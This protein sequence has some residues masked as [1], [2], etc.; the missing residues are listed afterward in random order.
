MIGPTWTP[1]E[2]LSDAVTVAPKLLGQY[3]V[4]KTPEGFVPAGLSKQ[5]LTAVPM[6]GS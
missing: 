4:H 2:F 5:K 6:T 1:R 3:L